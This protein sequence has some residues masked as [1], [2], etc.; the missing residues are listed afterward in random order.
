MNNPWEIVAIVL[1]AVA[2]VALYLWWHGKKSKG[3]QDKPQ[4]KQ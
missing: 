4:P 1:A 2:I 3:Q